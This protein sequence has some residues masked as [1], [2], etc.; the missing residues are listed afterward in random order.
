MN[1]NRNSCEPAADASRLGGSRHGFRNLQMG[2]GERDGSS[3]LTVGSV[4]LPD[5]E[6]ILVLP[7]LACYQ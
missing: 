6:I 3:R 5:L 4:Q 7:A 2:G 1:V